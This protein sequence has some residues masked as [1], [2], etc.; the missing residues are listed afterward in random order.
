[1]EEIPESCPRLNDLCHFLCYNS[2]H[3]GLV[4]EAYCL[5]GSV[6]GEEDPFLFIFS[7]GIHWC[8]SD[9]APCFSPDDIKD[10][11]K[12]SLMDFYA[13][14]YFSLAA[15]AVNTYGWNIPC[16]FKGT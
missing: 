12:P 9:P 2:L 11:V 16:A 15:S 10:C 7:P 1:M 5:V 8:D 6:I 4:L 3:G 14:D 13:P